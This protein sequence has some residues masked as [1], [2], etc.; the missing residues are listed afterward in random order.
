[1]KRFRKLLIVIGSV[2]IV[3][4]LGAVG[5][6]CSTFA[7]LAPSTAEDLA[8]NVH[9]V[10][11]GF[12]SAFLIDV[13]SNQVVLIDA[14]VDPEGKELLAALKSRG[15]GPEAVR[16]I[17][18]THGH[19]D[20]LAAVKLFAGAEVFA[21][22]TERAL[23]AG[24]AAPASP[25]GRFQRAKPTGIQ[26]SRGLSDG[27]SVR[28]GTV[29]VRA[30]AVPGHTDGSAAFLV[31]E[32]LLLGDAGSLTKDGRVVGPMWPFSVDSAQGR[33]SLR[34]LGK[35]LE[36]ERLNVQALGFAHSGSLMGNGSGALESVR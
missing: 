4:G 15:M 19:G 27:E 36:D 35:R 21:L 31:G 34:R 14:G 12:V 24:Q 22:E 7:G 28:V 2:L 26:L 10:R 6:Y 1:M 9:V 16:A 17:F 3:L 29:D 23:I 11:M 32:V 5:L 25:I 30:F 33:E 20:H 8:P 13:G 18:I